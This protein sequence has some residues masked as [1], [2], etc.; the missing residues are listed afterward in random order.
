MPSF[1]EMKCL[2]NIKALCNSSKGLSKPDV[3]FEVTLLRYTGL[4]FNINLLLES[5]VNMI[6]VYLTKCYLYH[7]KEI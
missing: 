3:I 6:K 7:E 2:Q 5:N 4:E 1:R